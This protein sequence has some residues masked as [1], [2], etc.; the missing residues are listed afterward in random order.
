[1]PLRQV[2][3]AHPQRIAA[4]NAAA[5][6]A[7]DMGVSIG[8]GV[9][10]SIPFEEIG[11]PVRAAFRWLLQELWFCVETLQL[12]HSSRALTYLVSFPSASRRE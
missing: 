9:G 4:V 1:V 8:T 5:A 6:A 12:Q 10:Y 7:D 2:V 11:T 3:C